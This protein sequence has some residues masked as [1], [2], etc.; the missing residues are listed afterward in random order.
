ME[1]RRPGKPA[2][3]QDDESGKGADP[4]TAVARGEQAVDVL[5]GKLLTCRG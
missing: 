5:L 2:V 4:K 1:C 3:P